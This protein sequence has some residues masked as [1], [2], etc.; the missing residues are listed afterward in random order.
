MN[1]KMEEI[2]A[3]ITGQSI[4]HI[5][6]IAATILEYSNYN[7]GMFDKNGVQGVDYISETPY[8][9]IIDT[10]KL[11]D[12]SY[13]Y[14][15]PQRNWVGCKLKYTISPKKK[16]EL[17][18]TLRFRNHYE[19]HAECKPKLIPIV[20]W[21]HQGWDTWYSPKMRK[22]IDGLHISQFDEWIDDDIYEA[23]QLN[24]AGDTYNF[25]IF[26][27][28]TGEE[29]GTVFE[30]TQNGQSIIYFDNWWSD[31]PLCVIIQPQNNAQIEIL[32]FT[33]KTFV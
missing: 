8:S 12:Y 23:V 13:I 28:T 32:N 16:E 1:E 31:H 15:H 29:I 7:D 11:R 33:K 4:P 2:V 10:I 27:K 14:G 25:E 30:V 17:H 9:P 5:K 22:H 20:T 21:F 19:D 18:W 6:G 24:E 26:V 3:H